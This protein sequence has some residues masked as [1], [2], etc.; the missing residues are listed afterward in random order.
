MVVVAG[1]KSRS[2]VRSMVRDGG[3][4][5]MSFWV[6]VAENQVKFR[7]LSRILLVKSCKRCAGDVCDC[8]MKNF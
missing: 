7:L 1:E 5:S 2:G 4:I 3:D 6:V 8:V